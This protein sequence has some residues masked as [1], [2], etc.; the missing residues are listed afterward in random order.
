MIGNINEIRE[1]G[2]RVLSKELG[3]AKA[4]VFMRQFEVGSAD[5]TEQRDELQSDVQI[6]D[7]VSRIKNRKNKS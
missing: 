4:A 3:A 7:I 1:E 2:L 6:D 5:Y